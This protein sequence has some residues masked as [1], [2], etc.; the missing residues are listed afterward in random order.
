M[1]IPCPPLRVQSSIEPR[2]VRTLKVKV[3]LLFLLVITVTI[4]SGIINITTVTK[5]VM[6]TV[7]LRLRLWT[8]ATGCWWPGADQNVT[9]Q[10]TGDFIYSS[11]SSSS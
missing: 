1:F 4:I 7:A 2:P 11:Q 10:H 5:R 9:D 6:T 3:T 8:A